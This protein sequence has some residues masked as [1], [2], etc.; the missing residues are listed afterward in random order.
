LPGESREDMS[1][2]AR[3]VAK[4]RLHSVKFHNLYAVKNT[5]LAEM[6]SA[7]A[8]VLPD[9]DT[10]ASYLADF[11]E[12]LPPDCVI[13]R[14]VG[15]APPEYLVAPR[16]CLDKS[17]VHAAIEKEMQC[18]DSWQGKYYAHGGTKS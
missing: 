11:L 6:V 17:A 13:E 14:L 16:W 9:R 18:R 5:V 3:E 7:G 2:T 1:A 10:Y 12:L 4:L 15:D 8:V